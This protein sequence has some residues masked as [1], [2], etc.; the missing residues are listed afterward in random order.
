MSDVDEDTV[1]SDV[2]GEEDRVEEDEKLKV[3]N[4]TPETI[5]EGLSLL[6]RTGNGLGHAFVKLDLKDKRLNDIAAISSYVHIRFLDVSNNQLTVLSPLASLIN[7][8]WLKVDNNALACLEGNPFTQLSYLQ[9]LSVAA[10]QLTDLGGLVGPA[11][12]TLNLT[13]NG[14]KTMKS[15]QM[16]CFGN[17]ATLELRG[18]LLKTTDGINLPNLQRLYLAQN[19]IKRLEG[20]EKLEHL[21]TLHLR[22]NQLE[23][24]DGL[25]PNMKCLQYL[26]VRGNAISDENTLQCLGLVSKTLRALVL[27]ENPLVET[28]DY[29]ISVL[30]LVPQLEQIDKEPVSPEERTEAQ[31]RIKELEEEEIA[32]P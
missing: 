20:L 17:L 22:D 4:L 6:C 30:I 19:A 15:L 26:N 23:S 31:E 8:L 24:L 7:L 2:D 13:G 32:E 27:S 25:S 29:R 14:I 1:M 28:T 11:L 21:T 16:G 18:N 3:S 12:E 9:W 5:G 10:N